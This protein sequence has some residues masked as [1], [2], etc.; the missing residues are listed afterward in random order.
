MLRIYAA[1][2]TA[3]PPRGERGVL[4]Q[5]CLQL[6][7]RVRDRRADVRQP[8][9]EDRA[10]RSQ[11]EQAHGVTH[12]GENRLPVD[13][14]PQSCGLVQQVAILGGVA[15]PR[16][17]V[18]D[19]R[20][21]QVRT[22]S[23]LFARAQDALFAVRVHLRF[24]FD[25]GDARAERAARDREDRV[26][27]RD[28]RT[29]RANGELRGVI[30]FGGAQDH[31]AAVE[32]DRHRAARSGDGELRAV[33]HLYARPVGHTQHGARIFRRPHDIAGREG[34]AARQHR[35][36]VIADA[37]QFAF[38]RFDRDPEAGVAERLPNKPAD[39]RT[40]EQDRRRDA[41]PR[42]VR[43]RRRAAMHRCVLR[44]PV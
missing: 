17:I 37:Q 27:R 6:I 15:A 43:E 4:L 44:C 26:V 3:L 19:R 5:T 35:H 25:H 12:A 39:E 20:R 24:A 30:L 22:R 36:R 14:V 9:V 29:R 28:C 13:R 16:D 34:R 8:G 32:V 7:V 38:R 41:P 33:V 23:D 2:A 10:A 18:G 42:G 1:R 31:V 40:R 11:I 21:L